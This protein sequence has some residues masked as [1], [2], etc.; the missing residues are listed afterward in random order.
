[1]LS[2]SLTPKVSLFQNGWYQAKLIASLWAIARSPLLIGGALPLDDGVMKILSQPDFLMVHTFARNQT[3]IEYTQPSFPPPHSGWVKWTARFAAGADK[4]AVRAVLVINAGNVSATTTTRWSALGLTGSGYVAR[5]VWSGEALPAVVGG[6]TTTV[7][8]LNGTLIVVR[9]AGK[10]AIDGPPMKAGTAT[11][12]NVA[13]PLDQNGEKLITGEADVLKHGDTYFLYFNNFGNCPGV[14]CCKSSG[15]CASCCFADPPSPYLPGC[16]AG[17]ATPG[18][19]R[20]THEQNS[21]DPYGFYHTVQVY[22][23]TDFK[24]FDNLGVALPLAARRFGVEFRPHVVYN[25][26]QR[27]FVMWF[28]NRLSS[29]KGGGYS[30]AVSHTA[31]GPFVTHDENVTMPGPGEIGDFDIFVDDDGS[32]YHVRTGLTIVKLNDEFTGPAPE[33]V[34]DLSSCGRKTEAPILFK[35]RGR[36]YVLAGACCCV[37]TG[38]SNIL[39]MMADSI[40]GPWTCAG[41][42]GSNPARFDAHSPNN[43]Q[44]HP[45]AVPCDRQSS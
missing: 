32:A 41:D 40:R 27:L 44:C 31:A 24:I 6:F 43:C 33:H 38:G 12:S 4:T 36:Y 37:C 14:D 16:G 8:R 25:A 2:V 30:V 35:R 3:V 23:T 34:G 22:S 13:L 29:G 10:R 15:G 20:L 26:K 42:V 39:V 9:R 11:L 17:N 21:S 1:M 19:P 45:S 5:D 18:D 28:E 7:G